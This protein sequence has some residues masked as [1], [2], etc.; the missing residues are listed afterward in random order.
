[1][2]EVVMWKFNLAPFYDWIV[3]CGLMVNQAVEAKK[4]YAM[5]KMKK[6]DRW[7]SM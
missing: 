5:P 7:P 2:R 3:G 4:A 1:M 6:P